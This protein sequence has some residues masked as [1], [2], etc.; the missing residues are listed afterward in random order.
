MKINFEALK[1]EFKNYLIEQ[2]LA[3]EL[4][5]DEE[6][7][8]V[9]IFEYDTEFIDFIEEEYKVDLEATSLNFS[10]LLDMKFEELFY[11]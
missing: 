5:S 9:S 6:L 11:F 10:E 2:G 3:P 7:S 4:A 8:G 1:N